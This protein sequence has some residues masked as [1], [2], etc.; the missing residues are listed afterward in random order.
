MVEFLKP[1]HGT[2]SEPAGE[3]GLGGVY[4]SVIGDL[5]KRLVLGRA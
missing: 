1:R 2:P 5:F 4:E 3:E